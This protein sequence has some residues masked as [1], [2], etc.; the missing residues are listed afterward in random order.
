MHKRAVAPPV[1]LTCHLFLQSDPM[2]W[3]YMTKSVLEK[4]LGY[5]G[6][7]RAGRVDCTVSGVGGNKRGGE[8]L[9]ASAT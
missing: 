1:N 3:N 5:V 7:Q 2:M 8:R 6:H 4:G 9:R